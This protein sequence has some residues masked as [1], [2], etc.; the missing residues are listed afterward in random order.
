MLVSHMQFVD[1]MLTF[2]EKSWGNI[3]VLKVILFLWDD[4]RVK[5][6]PGVSWSGEWR[7]GGFYRMMEFS[8]EGGEA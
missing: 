8:W 6:G 2:G 1:D 7:F 3:R 5:I 4:F